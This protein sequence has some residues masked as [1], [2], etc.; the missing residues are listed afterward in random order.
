[1]GLGYPVVSLGTSGVF[2]MPIDKPESQTKGKKILF[3]FDDKKFQYL[4][5]GVVQCNGNTFDWWNKNIME[6]KRFKE[7]TTS[8]DVNSNAQNDLIFYPHLDGDKTIYAD[9]EL[10][11]AFIGLNLTTSQENLFYAVIEGLCFGFRELAEKMHLPL[12]KYGTV[13]VVGGGAK[14]PVWLQTMANV[15]NIAVEKMEGMIGPA[16]GIALL[17][18]YKGGSITSLE[19]ISEGNVKIECRHEPDAEAVKACQQKYEK[20]LRIRS[21]LQYIKNGVIE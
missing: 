9:P 17:A 16:F 13:K 20:Y 15:L 12:E 3:S 8:I 11:G 5:Q 21:G 2:M 7:L 19:Q 14:S 4:V 18:A 6:L 10:R 1:M